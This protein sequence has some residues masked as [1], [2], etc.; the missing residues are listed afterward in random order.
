MCYTSCCASSPLPTGTHPTLNQYDHEP[1]HSHHSFLSS[2]TNDNQ[3]WANRTPSQ[4]AAMRKWSGRAFVCWGKMKMYGE[5]GGSMQSKYSHTFQWWTSQHVLIAEMLGV[6]RA[7]SSLICKYEESCKNTTCR[8]RLNIRPQKYL[9]GTSPCMEVRRRMTAYLCAHGAVSAYY[10]MFLCSTVRCSV[11]VLKLWHLRER[12]TV[13][14]ACDVI[15]S[16]DKRG[17][18]GSSEKGTC[19][20]FSLRHAWNCTPSQCRVRVECMC[21][22]VCLSNMS[23]VGGLLSS[24]WTWMF[25]VLFN[26]LLFS[27]LHL[28]GRSLCLSHQACNADIKRSFLSS[29]PDCPN[30]CYSRSPAPPR[31]LFNKWLEVIQIKLH[32]SWM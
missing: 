24:V 29:A 2:L 32:W 20:L 21:V 14:E 25:T 6:P 13:S 23:W 12:R 3:A 10:C 4:P 5:G 26:T 7:V 11:C 31:T 19:G 18:G 17:R 1:L 16:D 9:Q 28:Q 15:G 8:S 27:S 22:C 30:K